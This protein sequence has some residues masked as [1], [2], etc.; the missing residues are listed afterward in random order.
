MTNARS[1]IAALL[2]PL[3]LA[4]APKARPLAGVPA[5]ARFP[6]SEV[7]QGHTRIVFRW[8]YTEGD[9][10]AKGEGVARIAAPDSVRL[11]FFLGGAVGGTSTAFLIGDSLE[12]PGNDMFRRLIPPV[13][14]LW[15]SL[16]RLRAPAAADTMARVDADTLRAD[17]GRNPR[18]RV[19]FAGD[20]LVR[21]ERI[22]DNRVRESV[23]RSPNDDVTYANRDARRTLKLTVTKNEQVADFEREIWRR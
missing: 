14:M 7:P 13:P 23:A 10:E 21:M 6:R 9:I 12:T 5:P 19:T 3:A 16:G 18:W 11:D 17:I 2:A 8:A 15:A 4:C 20:R 1:L 22:H